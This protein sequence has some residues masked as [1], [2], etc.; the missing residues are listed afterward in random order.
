MT[1]KQ[2]KVFSVYIESSP[3][4]FRFILVFGI[5]V[6]FFLVNE[7]SETFRSKVF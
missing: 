1:L 6:V 4:Y 3:L 5:F 7:I 2:S